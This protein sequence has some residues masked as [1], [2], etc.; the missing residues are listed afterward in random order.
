MSGDNTLYPILERPSEFQLFTRTQEIKDSIKFLQ[1]EERK[2]TKLFR[3]G[4]RL[5]NVDNFFN[6][7]SVTGMT[8]GAGGAVSSMVGITVPISVSAIAVGGAFSLS[9]F[10]VNTTVK[11]Y[12]RKQEKYIAYI[13]HLSSAISELKTKYYKAMDDKTIDESEFSRLMKIVDDYKDLKNSKRLSSQSSSSSKNS[14][15]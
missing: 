12:N 13:I 14:M 7:V 6:A 5:N 1:E 9:A 15:G 8:I 11:L 2:Y 3:R 4:K 10:M